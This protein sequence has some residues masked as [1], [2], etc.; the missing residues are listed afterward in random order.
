MFVRQSP[1]LTL[2]QYMAQS[3]GVWRPVCGEA[4]Y[5][6]RF[7]NATEEGIQILIFSLKSAKCPAKYGY[8]SGVAEITAVALYK[9][10]TTFVK[11]Y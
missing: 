6:T 4:N 1:Q 11:I 2:D 7:F 3:V 10:G 5:Q 8:G 9:A